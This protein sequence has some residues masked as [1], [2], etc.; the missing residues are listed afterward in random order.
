M[1]EILTRAPLRKLHFPLFVFV[2]LVL[3]GA[4]SP[5]EIPVTSASFPFFQVGRSVALYTQRD[6]LA[7]NFVTSVIV[8]QGGAVWVGTTGGATR[9]QNGRWT[10]FM[11]LH[12]LGADWV[13]SLAAAPD[14]RIWFGTQGGG[15]SVFDGS[16]F[17]SYDISKSP[18]PSNFVTAVA[19]DPRGTIWLGTLSNGA[20]KFDPASNR[21]TLYELPNDSITALTIDQNGLPWAGTDGAGA[22]SFDGSKW[23]HV[24]LPGSGQ[25]SRVESFPGQGILIRTRDGQFGFDGDKWGE[26]ELPVQVLQ[27]ASELSI[28]PDQ[29]AGSASDSEGHIYV[30]TPRGLGVLT[31]P[32]AAPLNPPRPLPVVLVHGWTVSAE[33]D[34]QDSEFRFLQQYAQQDGIPVY[35]ARGID[36]KNT[37][38]ENAARLRDDLAQVEQSTGSSKVNVIAFSMGGLNARAYLESSIYQGDVNRVIILGTPEAGVDIWNPIL[39]QQIVQKPEEPSAIELSPEFAALFNQTHAARKGIP[40]DL[41]AGDARKQPQMEFIADLPA[42]DGLIGV[43]SALSLVGAGVR[44]AVNA[45][46]HAFEPSAI[47]FD[48]TSYLYP[49][50]TYTR[51]LRNA[52]R[53]ATN[54]PIGSEVASPTSL[55]IPGLPGPGNHTPVVTTRLRASETVTQTVTLDASTHARFIAYFPGGDLDLSLKGPDGKT[56]SSSGTSILQQA[57]GKAQNG[58][59]ALKADIANFFGYSLSGTAPGNWSLVLTRKDNG[60][61]PLDVTT[62]VDLDAARRLDAGVNRNNIRLGESVTITAT[63]SLPT[64]DL[65]LSARI[66]VPA[67]QPGGAFSYVDLPLTNN[68][69]GAYSAFFTPPRGGYYPVFVTATAPDFARGTEFLFAVNP[70]GARLRPGPSVVIQRDGSG[71]I[72]ALEFDVEFDA[73]RADNFALGASLNSA[74]GDSIERFTTPVQ[75]ASGANTVTLKFDGSALTSPGP[76]SL[77]LTLL[78]TTWAAVQVDEIKN[79]ATVQP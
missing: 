38:F 58:A 57:A 76:Y 60:T 30:A 55:S 71:R 62:Y 21:W 1:F 19:A 77:D 31:L 42:D 8:A 75:A 73:Q 39:A 69:G 12:G 35:Y 29:I 11:H 2:S 52:L 17:S 34:I 40:Y 4:L 5:I 3:F 49:A 28:P 50:D 27:A 25:V 56:Y 22:F 66:A 45:D 18:I 33:D 53:D 7:G 10:D 24:D 54:A 41:L 65:N 32:S 72:S 63:V 61:A 14:G 67:A 70:G 47:P 6:G 68:G 16:S 48:L 51:Y 13:T 78:D 9:I 20:A 59:L 64:P 23:K 79:A 46:L 44:R 74:N 36:P 26:A 37:L 43:G 15:L